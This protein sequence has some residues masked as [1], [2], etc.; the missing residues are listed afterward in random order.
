MDHSAVSPLGVPRAGATPSGERPISIV[1]GLSMWTPA[2]GR[3]A[4][5]AA[6]TAATSSPA[7]RADSPSAPRPEAPGGAPGP[8]PP[9][10]RCL[11]IRADLT[12]DI[13]PGWLR[14]QFSGAMLYTLRTRAAGGGCDDPAD[15]RRERLIAAA[16]HYD[17]VDLDADHD[18]HADVLD[19][20]PP[21]RRVLSWHGPATDLAGL[22]RTFAA[23][24]TVDAHLYRL[25]PAAK[26]MAQALAPLLLLKSLERADVTAYARGPAATWTRVLAARYGAA[27]AFGRLADHGPQAAARAAAEGDLPVRRLLIDYPA[28]LV[29]RAERLYGILG[30]STSGSLCPMAHNTGY[31]SL[32]LPALF[33]PFSSDELALSLAD[34]RT[35]LDELGLPLGAMA[36][37]APHKDAAFTLAT[38]ATPFARRV[39]AASLLLRAPSG[40]WADT[41]AAGI[42]AALAGKQVNVA[43][44]RIAVVGC[45]GAGRSAAAGLS[46][47]G[48]LV[49]L[50]NRGIPGG[51]RAAKLVDLPFVPLAE[52]DPRAY[53]VLVHATPVKDAM[54]FPLD[55]LDPGTVIFDLSYGPTETPLVAAARAAGHRTID[56]SEMTLVELPRQ[57]HRM[58]GHHIPVGIVRAAQRE[59][60]K[61][62][63]RKAESADRRLALS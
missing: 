36:V 8:R 3:A 12:G 47:A 59:F 34:L 11:E 18:L 1:A 41:E 21:E 5:S 39:A 17:Y 38:E 40:W 43:R 62:R 32:G 53:D 25:A 35:G 16:A 24:S 49:T 63:V 28:D 50:V 33:L 27:V 61:H 6:L 58:T 37:V 15:R 44:R 30:A 48:G 19:R 54:L 55:G 26:T 31:R 56:G 60:S 2:M 45:G 46:Q 52:F 7:L 9:K 14:E 22:R 23:L 10:I 57:F 29:L 4:L 42:V 51:L 20:I 13:N